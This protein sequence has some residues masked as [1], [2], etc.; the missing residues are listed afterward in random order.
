MITLD[1][2][3]KPFKAFVKEIG[4]YSGNKPVIVLPYLRNLEK[5]KYID[6]VL[7]RIK[8]MLLT[9]KST[10]IYVVFPIEIS[11]S[12]RNHIWKTILGRVNNLI[13]V[14]NEG[15]VILKA[16][17]DI[18]AHVLGQMMSTAIGIEKY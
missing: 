5:D 14:K 6:E 18:P 1:K 11:K 2:S 17:Y 15:E 10:I 7:A 13:P 4:S 8:E 12:V 16:F 3:I 9:E